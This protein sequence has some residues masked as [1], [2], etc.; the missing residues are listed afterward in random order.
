MLQQRYE[1]M[2]RVRTLLSQNISQNICTTTCIT[3]VKSYEDITYS[4]TNRTLHPL[5]TYDDVHNHSSVSSR[6]NFK[7]GGSVMC[8]ERPVVT[9]LG[10]TR[11]REQSVPALTTCS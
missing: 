6:I 9:M 4:L 3:T 5:K 11:L 10:E 2:Y 1:D 8:A 7:Q